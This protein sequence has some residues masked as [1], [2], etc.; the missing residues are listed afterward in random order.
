MQQDIFSKLNKT[1]K[2]CFFLILSN[3]RPLCQP[4]LS[5]VLLGFYF[6]KN[7]CYIDTSSQLN[8]FTGIIIVMRDIEKSLFPSIASSKAN[9]LFFIITVNETTT[10][11]KE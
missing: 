11:E 2:L 1:L 7:L 3:L 10:E 8:W 9:G 4:R 6:A 5:I